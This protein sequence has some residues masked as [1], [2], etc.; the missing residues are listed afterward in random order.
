MTK[1]APVASPG[2][3]TCHDERSEA[4]A[5]LLLV[6]Y[7][8]VANPLDRCSLPARAPLL[9]T[10][11]PCGHVVLNHI[12]Q[13]LGA[14]R[15]TGIAGVLRHEFPGRVE[16]ARGRV[17]RLL[18]L[19]RRFVDHDERRVTP[20]SL[21]QRFGSFRRLRV[22][23]GVLH[24]ELRLHLWT[25]GRRLPVAAQLIVDEAIR[26]QVGPFGAGIFLYHF[27][28]V[29]LVYRKAQSGIAGLCRGTSG[30]IFSLDLPA[31]IG[32]AVERFCCD[33]RSREVLGDAR[34][35]PHGILRS[36]L[37]ASTTARLHLGIEGLAEEDLVAVGSGSGDYAF[38]DDPAGDVAI[39]PFFIAELDRGRDVNR[40]Y[41]M[42]PSRRALDDGNFAA[43]SDVGQLGRGGV[44]RN[45]D[46]AFTQHD[47]AF[48]GES[49]EGRDDKDDQ[50]QTTRQRK[51]R[52]TL[53]AKA[54][55]HLS[56]LRRG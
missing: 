28:H 31:D 14:I 10:R 20:G 30:Q 4:S 55:A 40:A 44:G 18:L 8:R 27:L 50:Y 11:P 47:A 45:V 3:S 39:A 52:H 32:G 29:R 33:R 19:V 42:Y 26:R 35:E 12:Y 22:V 25:L 49:G 36:A 24:V 13:T 46:D 38:V 34:I 2:L 56:N 7:L 48:G 43:A 21:I 37:A 23:L 41:D 6:H 16:R 51:Q 17:V 53:R 9:K 15:P 1:P 54:P 5:F